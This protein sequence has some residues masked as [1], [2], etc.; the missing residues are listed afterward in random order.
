MPDYAELARR[1]SKDAIG[2]FCAL[3]D[4]GRL[5]DYSENFEKHR[6]HL[7]P[8]DSEGMRIQAFRHFFVKLNLLPSLASGLRKIGSRSLSQMVL[9]AESEYERTIESKQN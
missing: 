4:I 3:A 7:T 5:H 6:R 9:E 1:L 8:F 2:E